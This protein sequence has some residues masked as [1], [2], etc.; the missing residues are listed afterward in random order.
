MNCT[1]IKDTEEKLKTRMIEPDMLPNSKCGYPTYIRPSNLVLMLKSGRCG[2][3]IPFS[4]SWSGQKKDTVVN[5]I[6]SHCPFCGVAME[7]DDK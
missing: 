3:Q 4:V 5:I 2:L 7:S 1:C 6:A